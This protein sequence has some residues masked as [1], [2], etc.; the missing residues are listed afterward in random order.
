M[1]AQKPN[2][3]T[4]ELSIALLI[5]MIK[6]L[7]RDISAQAEHIDMLRGAG[8]NA[9]ELAEEDARLMRLAEAQRRAFARIAH[10][11]ANV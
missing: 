9:E 2:A 11:I 3:G 8:A 5:E 1:H 10:T 7:G 6:E 4:V